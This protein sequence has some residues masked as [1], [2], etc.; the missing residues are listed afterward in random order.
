MPTKIKLKLIK[1]SYIMSEQYKKDMSEASQE[2]VGLPLR[3][4]TH[5][6][7]LIERFLKRILL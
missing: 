6:P 5:K 2:G 7:R 4:C 1:S 3:S